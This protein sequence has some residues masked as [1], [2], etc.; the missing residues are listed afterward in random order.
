MRDKWASVFVVSVV[1]L[2]ALLVLFFSPLLDG[3]VMGIVFAYV[4]KPIKKRVEEK[5]GKAAA[6]LIATLLI[7]VPIFIL[8][9]YGIFQGINQLVYLFTHQ[10]EVE[11]MLVS[12]LRDAGIDEKYIE[13]VRLWI[14]SVISLAQGKLKISAIDV[15]IRAVMFFMN[16]IISAIVCFYVLLDADSFVRKTIRIFPESRQKEIARFIAE[17][18]ETLLA[19]WFGNFAFAVIIGLVSI[20]FFMA[21]RIPYAPLLSGLMFLAALIPVFAEWMVL[22][23]VALFLALTN[24]NMAIW[25]TAIGFLFLYFLP[26]VVLRPYFVGHASRIH[27]LALLLA[28]IGGAMVGGVAGFFVAPM[29]VAV[30]TAVYNYYTK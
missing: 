18:D 7:I 28:F 20:P 16:F 25:F 27:P 9:F 30:I 10:H 21:F 12:T 4:A 13:D 6:S 29:V 14:P 3:I 24:L 22:A 19:L 15:T 5:T 1:A 17:V 11:Q 8:M 2:L 26:E 23:P